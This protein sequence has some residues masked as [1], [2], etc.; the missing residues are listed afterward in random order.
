M[1]SPN[2]VV[3]ESPGARPGKIALHKSMQALSRVIVSL[4][5]GAQQCHICYRDS[6]L[7]KLLKASLGGR[8]QTVVIETVCLLPENLQDTLNTMKFAGLAKME[9][10]I[11]TRLAAA[12]PHYTRRGVPRAL[13][14]HCDEL[15]VEEVGF[16]LGGELGDHIKQAGVSSGARMSREEYE[17]V[18]QNTKSPVGQRRQLCSVLDDAIEEEQKAVEEEAKRPESATDDEEADLSDMFMV[19]KT[20]SLVLYDG[21][22]LDDDDIEA[23]HRCDTKK[24]EAGVVDIECDSLKS[25]K[26]SEIKETKSEIKET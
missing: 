14:C 26:M 20:A 16:M 11:E 8:A 22:G 23:L 19:N 4:R 18:M 21:C 9:E 24:L 13:D 7:T 5:R 15:P 6:N 2:D 25:E 1:Y 17:W 3:A 12:Q 10:N